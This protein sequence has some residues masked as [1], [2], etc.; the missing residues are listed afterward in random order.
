MEVARSL[1]RPEVPLRRFHVLMANRA[2]ITLTQDRNGASGRGSSSDFVPA[3]SM[4]VYRRSTVWI[5][6]LFCGE[7]GPI[8]PRVDLIRYNFW[9][10]PLNSGYQRDPQYTR[11][12]DLT[13]TEDEL[14]ADMRATPRRH[15]RQAQRDDFEYDFQFPATMEATN[16]FCDFY[17]R[18]GFLRRV[19]SADRART[20]A[21][22]SAGRLEINR[23][24]DGGST[25]VLHA[26]VRTQ[27]RVVLLHSCSTFRNEATSIGR[28]RVAHANRYLHWQELLRWKGQGLEV[29]DFGGWYNGDKDAKLLAVNQFKAGFGGRV[30]PTHNAILARSLR[31]RL[32]LEYLR[33]KDLNQKW[34]ASMDAGT[35]E[36]AELVGYDGCGQGSSAA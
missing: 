1:L 21:L 2:T 29:F 11:I 30:E 36:S 19:A 33:L 34:I 6:D 15:I 27:R 12:I 25:V 3:G 32:A 31:G 9:P 10:E 35:N 13:H 16:H 26:Y 17:E 23:V 7:S 20:Q 5:G 28:N 22:A 24:M 18:F 4:V 14:F 8:D